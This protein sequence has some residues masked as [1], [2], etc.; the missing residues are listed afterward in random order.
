MT[1]TDQT[2]LSSLMELAH[3]IAVV[4]AEKRELRVP[5]L[6]VR[7]EDERIQSYNLEGGPLHPSLASRLICHTATVTHAAIAF[8][9][10]AVDIPISPTTEAEVRRDGAPNLG[11]PPSRHPDRYDQLIVL[12][13]TRG[14]PQVRWSW[15]IHPPAADGD[16]RTFEQQHDDD[17]TYTGLPSNFNPLFVD[18]AQLRALLQEQLRYERLKTGVQ[19]ARN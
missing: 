11:A 15:R 16:L 5:A 1:E 9:G 17:D 3:S 10:W 6:V 4:T 2:I 13:E 14:R 18:H 8:E 12:G 19:A 7:T